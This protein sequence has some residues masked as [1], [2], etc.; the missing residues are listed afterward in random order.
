MQQASVAVLLA[1]H[2]QGYP[3]YCSAFVSSHALYSRKGMM[4]L[5]KVISAKNEAEYSLS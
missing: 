2:L 5:I 1:Q 3:Q 4:S